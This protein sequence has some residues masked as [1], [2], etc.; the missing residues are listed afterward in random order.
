[1]NWYYDGKEF[2]YGN[3]MPTSL[4]YLSNGTLYL[5]DPYVTEERFFDWVEEVFGAQHV[6]VLYDMPISAAT[7]ERLRPNYEENGRFITI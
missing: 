4:I 5:I 7:Y 6:M 1:M 3:G 2:D